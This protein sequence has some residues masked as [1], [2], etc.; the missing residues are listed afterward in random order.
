[1]SR[2]YLARLGFQTYPLTFDSP[3]ARISIRLHEKIALERRLSALRI[4]AS[5]S[6]VAE[7]SAHTGYTSLSWSF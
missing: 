7:L 5:D 4:L 3:M 1:M 2:L 6:A